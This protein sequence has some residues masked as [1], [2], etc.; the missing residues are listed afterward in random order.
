MPPERERRYAE[1]RA[2]L[3]TA[4][5]ERGIAAHGQSGLGVWIPIQEETAAV[6]ALA[7]R[8]W[9]VSAGERYRYRSAPGLR[10]TTTTLLPADARRLADDIAAITGSRAT[11]YSG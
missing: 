11:T 6:Q 8:G 2:A 9:A 10:V 1:R 7:E 5:A 4:L 3:V